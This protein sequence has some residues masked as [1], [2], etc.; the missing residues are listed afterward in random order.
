MYL[1]Y[2]LLL[3]VNNYELVIFVSLFKWYK[4]YTCNYIYLQLFIY[5]VIV[6]LLLIN[7]FRIFFLL[8]LPP[9]NWNPSSATASSTWLTNRCTD[10]STWLTHQLGKDV[11]CKVLQF[12][13][14]MKIQKV[15]GYKTLG[16]T[17]GAAS[18]KERWTR[19]Y[20]SDHNML[21]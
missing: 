17:N 12:I 9:L 21:E 6:N 8:I 2:S 14:T 13:H 7:I 19:T 1:H 20:V 16:S 5:F 3:I 10:P 11:G 4:T 18:S 15:L